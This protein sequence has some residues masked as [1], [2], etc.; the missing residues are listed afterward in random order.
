M[1]AISNIVSAFSTTTIGTKVVDHARFLSLV[2][3]AISTYDWSACRQAGQ[4]FINLP[5]E[6]ISLVS[7]G[8]GKH[9]HNQDDYVVRTH[10]G[11][12]GL[13]LKREKAEV[14]TGVAVVVYTREAY[15]NDPQ[16]I[17]GNRQVSDEY[18]HVLVAVL[19]FAGPK[20][21]VGMGRFVI[22]LAGGNNEYAQYTKEEVVMK[23]KACHEYNSQWCT[24]A[25]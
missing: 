19:G 12:V 11:E 8:C 3:S 9:T 20:P 4:G 18:T 16:V 13:Y 2:D 22:N 7:A 25:D 21:E 17:E 1:L 14:C 23:A 5:P 6:A 24:V 15:N 10:R